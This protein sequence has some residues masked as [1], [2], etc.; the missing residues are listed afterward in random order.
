MPL[1]NWYN[2]GTKHFHQTSVV[3]WKWKTQLD[4]VIKP[5]PHD[6]VW[7]IRFWRKKIS[8]TWFKYLY[9]T[10]SKILFWNLFICKETYM[11][12]WVG[13]FVHISYSTTVSSCVVSR[14]VSCMTSYQ[15]HF[16]LEQLW[17][18]CTCSTYVCTLTTLSSTATDADSELPFGTRR[19]GWITLR[20]SNLQYC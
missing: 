3:W 19:H 8:G 7:R 20:S 10:I 18:N 4:W 9:W 1:R 11:I 17:Y 2:C 15:T 6:L 14:D 12:D 16:L 5:V 13:R